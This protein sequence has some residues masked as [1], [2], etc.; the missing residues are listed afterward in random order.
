MGLLIS[1]FCE[2]TKFVQFLF[3]F[4]IVVGFKL[5]YSV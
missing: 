3:V 4:L 2:I 5:M 1:F